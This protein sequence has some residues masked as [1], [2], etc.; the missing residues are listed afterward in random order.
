[1]RSPVKSAWSAFSAGSSSRLGLWLTKKGVGVNVN[2]IPLPPPPMGKPQSESHQKALSS[3][4]GAFI[5]I[6]RNFTN[7]AKKSKVK[8]K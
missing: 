1:M 6:S 4:K 5:K 2:S 7:M 3:E 8:T